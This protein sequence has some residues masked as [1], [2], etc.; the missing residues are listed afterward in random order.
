MHWH[1]IAVVTAV[2]T[3]PLSGVSADQTI[4][5]LKKQIEDLDQK[6]RI[7]E[8]KAEVETEQ[9]TGGA[10]ESPR[11]TAG[12]SGFSFSSADTN[13]LLKVRGY[14]Q[15]DA[16]FYIDDRIPA[17]DTFL[18]RRVRPIFEGTV[19]QHYDYRIMLDFASGISSSSANNGFLQDAYLNVHYWPQFQIQVGKM[20]PPVGL[21]R[22]QS[23]ANL[24]FIERGYPTQLAPNR[25]VGV[26]LH[27]QIFDGAVN[28]AAG[29]FNGVQDGASGD[30]DSGSDDHKDA[31]ARLFVHP[32][33]NTQI[34]LLQGLGIGIAGTYGNQAGPLRSFVTPGQQNF[35]SYTTGTG[36]NANVTADGTHWRLVPQAYYYWGPFGVF[37]EYVISSEKL[38][39]DAGGGAP[40][41]ITARNRAWQV[42]AS[43]ILTGEKNSFAPL[44]PA[45]P[46]RFG[47]GWG[48]WELA[49]R[50]GELRVDDELFPQ[51]A[52]SSSARKARSWAGG[53]NWYLNRNVKLSLNYEQTHFDGG[54]SRPGTVTAQNEK[55]ILSR[56]QF[57]F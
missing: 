10:K 31:A 8:R 47:E 18:M 29:V 1:K 37:G 28:Y 35:F 12:A 30:S 41:F 7:I 25:D 22:L 50:Y 42:A 46:F 39:R 51:F 14:V 44:N 32:F 13:F 40:Q 11:L 3:L 36:T 24:L 6:I 9:R 16:R 52:T 56:V 55:V 26:Q 19:F 21:E 38:R 54:S 43:Y 34:E 45:R 48:A 5:E 15:A 17:N 2:I 27:G 4:G 49:A 23:G 57:G 53:I 33:K 20:K